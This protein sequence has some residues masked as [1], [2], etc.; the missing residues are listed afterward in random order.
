M[1]TTHEPDWSALRAL[2]PV[3]NSWAHLNSAAFGPIPTTGVQAI[4]D[5]FRA[6][7]ESAALDFPTWFDR[8][9]RIRGKIARL[10]GA[11]ADDIGF[12]PSA[13]AGL[14]WLLRGIDWRAGDE[15]IGFQHEFPNNQYAPRLLDSEGV[16]FRA[17]PTPA[18]I[19]QPDLILDAVGPRT[20]LVLISSVNYSN[21][22]RAPLASLAPVLRRKGVLLCVDATQTVGALSL[23]LSSTPVD[24]LVAHG[25]KWLMAPAGAGFVYVPSATRAWLAP[26]IVSWRSHRAWRDFESLHHGRPE[27][28]QDASIY[29]GGVQSF[30][31]LFALEASLDLILD[32]GKESIERRVLGLAQQCRQIL[33]AH[34]G[35]LSSRADG[36]G[37]SQIVTAAFPRLDGAALRRRLEAERVAVSLRQGNLRVSPHF[38]NNDADLGRLAAVLAC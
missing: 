29:E 17:L 28:P 32:C 35:V 16:R 11:E 27:L 23:D 3:L 24:F 31:P 36:V 30:A 21:G 18:D 38:F 5:H 25:Y 9:D 22:L 1:T 33:T 12:C 19:L 14:A 26:S 2:F 15:V 6:R 34:G 10:I 37:G 8:L 4:Q 7:D 13:G 20:R